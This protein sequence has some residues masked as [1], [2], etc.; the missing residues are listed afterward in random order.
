MTHATSSERLSSRLWRRYGA[1]AFELLE[2]IR[3]DA[4]MSDLLIEGAEYIKAELYFTAKFEMVTKLED[5]LRRRSKIA[6]VA[7]K[8]TIEHAPGMM[9]AC[10]ILFG[11]QAQEKFDEYFK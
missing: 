5:F 7:R 3:Q 2:E 9:E 11:D 8:R 6:L 1:R 4:S 10:K